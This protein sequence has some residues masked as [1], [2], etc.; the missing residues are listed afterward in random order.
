MPSDRDTIK[1]TAAMLRG[2]SLEEYLAQSA[3]PVPHVPTKEELELECKC[4]NFIGSWGIYSG[5]FKDHGQLLTLS[6]G[7]VVELRSWN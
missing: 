5:H 4:P 2:M 1:A 7:S 3:P 6:E